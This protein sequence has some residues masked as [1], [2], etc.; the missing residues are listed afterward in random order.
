MGAQRVA[1]DT[2]PEMQVVIPTLTLAVPERLFALALREMPSIRRATCLI[3]SPKDDF[4]C[5]EEGHG[6]IVDDFVYVTPWSQK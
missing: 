2:Y 6:T 4:R 1:I 5:L 3:K